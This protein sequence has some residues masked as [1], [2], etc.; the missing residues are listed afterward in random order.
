MIWELV[1][2]YWK[3]LAALLLVAVGVLMVLWAGYSIADRSWQAKWHARDQ[4]DLQAKLEFTEQQRRIE[5]QRQGAIDAIQ[6]Q[7][8]KDIATAQRNAAIAAAESKRL[9]DGIADAIA[10]LQAD[11]GN[12]GATISSK[13]RASTSSLLAVLF[14]EIDAAAGEYAA[15]ADRARKAGLRCEAAYD[16][17]RNSNDLTK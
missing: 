4:G 17:V 16:A 9:Q 14:R 7:A 2:A 15:E 10:R 6:E 5:L 13:A 3:P 1:K 12:A 11:S 8:Q